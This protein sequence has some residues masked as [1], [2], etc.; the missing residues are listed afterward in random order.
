MNDVIMVVMEILGTV[1]FAISGA[2]IS[3]SCSLDVFGVVF[4][5]VITAIGGGILRDVLIGKCPPVI[6]SNTYIFGVALVTSLLVFIIA[7]CNR[8]HFELLKAKIDRVNNVFDAIGLSAFTITGT[9]MACES[10]FSDML[11]L[12]VLMGMITGVGG[13]IIRDLLVS[14]IP[15]VLKKHVYA[16]ASVCGSIIYYSFH[17]YFNFGVWGTLI[18]ILSVFFIRILSTLYQWNLP[19]IEVK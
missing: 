9:E 13:G 8:E 3:I 2:L 17:N 6:F 10:C 5:G 12:V 7:Y 4:V 19:K 14:K 18:A 16:L 1:A 15:Y 11:L